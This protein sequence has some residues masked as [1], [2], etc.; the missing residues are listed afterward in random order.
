MAKEQRARGSAEG[1]RTC[2]TYPVDVMYN[3][4]GIWDTVQ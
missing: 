4:A 1:I 3:T 2:S